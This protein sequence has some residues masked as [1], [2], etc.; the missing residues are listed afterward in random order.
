MDIVIGSLANELGLSDPMMNPRE[1]ALYQRS[2][3]YNNI[4]L[5]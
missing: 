3:S 5:I 2:C 1:I 4:L